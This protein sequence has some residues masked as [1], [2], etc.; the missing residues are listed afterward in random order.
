MI[1]DLALEPPTIELEIVLLERLK[2]SVTAREVFNVLQD[3]IKE[4]T[5][6]DLESFETL[7]RFIR[8]ERLHRE[9][10]SIKELPLFSDQ[11]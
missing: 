4:M 2:F 6:G 1:P 11:P 7:Y 5:D 8:E 3:A 10:L 9:G